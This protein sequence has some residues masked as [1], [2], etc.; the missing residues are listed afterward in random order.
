MQTIKVT[1]TQ[2]IDIDY[3]LAGIGE[4]TLARV[5]DYAIFFGVY[6]ACFIVGAVIF[7]NN[8]DITKE[9]IIVVIWLIVCVLYD[10]VAEVFF[11]GQSVGKAAMKIKVISLNG[12]RPSVGQYLLRWV[13]RLVDFGVSFGSAAMITFIF[14]DNNQRIGDVVAGTTVV[15]LTP[16]TQYHDLVFIPVNAEGEHLVSYP[17]AS[18]LTDED[19]V[20]IHDVI[21]NFNRTRNSMM[22]YKLAVRIRKFLNVVQPS[23]IN[24][25]QFLE[26]ILADYN[27]LTGNLQA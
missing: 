14:S 25:Y 17:E 26:I 18:Q 7:T 23:K 1:T 11:N 8:F 13:F 16:T 22:I 27:Y 6:F 9:R 21:R 10:L 12:H 2:N 15:R 4:R 3:T 20:L 19:V 24:E 5:I